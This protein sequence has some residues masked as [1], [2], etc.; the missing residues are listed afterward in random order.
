MRAVTHVVRARNELAEATKTLTDSGGE[1]YRAVT[2]L[3]EY[4]SKLSESQKRDLARYFG[5]G[6]LPVVAR[7]AHNQEPNPASE[8]EAS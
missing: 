2:V 8:L 1:L 6:N 3:D 7:P 5:V 4:L